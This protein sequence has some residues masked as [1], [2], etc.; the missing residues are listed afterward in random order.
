MR[1]YYRKV[2]THI[3]KYGADSPDW[4]ELKPNE[5]IVNFSTS[6][7][8]D[9]WYAHIIICVQEKES[10]LNRIYRALQLVLYGG[11]NV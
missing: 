11:S 2:S 10:L 8:L 5:K 1:L 4:V 3:S 7:E 6:F 9:G